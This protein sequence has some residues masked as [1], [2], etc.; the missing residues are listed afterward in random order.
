MGA[1][2]LGLVMPFVY[3]WRREHEAGEESG[4]KIRPCLIVAVVRGST[5]KV[6]V[7]VA[8]LTSQEPETQR[9]AIAIPARVRTHL[10]LEAAASW[11]IC[12][13]YNEFDWPG[14]D[15]GTTPKGR[16]VFG[17]VPDALL[18]Q[19]RT[20]MFAARKR[21]ALKSIPRTG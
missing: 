2:D 17:Y 19:V 20:E 14:V 6:R 15:I 10:R 4:R 11:V 1:P 8:P 16:S 9:S 5:G 7:A 18:E 13:E 21:G 12:D 3:L